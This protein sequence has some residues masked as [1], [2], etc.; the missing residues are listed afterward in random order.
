MAC[1]FLWCWMEVARGRPQNVDNAYTDQ[2]AVGI[3][4]TKLTVSIIPL[5]R[6]FWRNSLKIR[7][8]V[9]SISLVGCNQFTFTNSQEKSLKADICH[10][11]RRSPIPQPKP[12]AA[13]IHP[14]ACAK[15]MSWKFQRQLF[16]TYEGHSR[17]K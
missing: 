14:D 13:C 2:V 7:C 4:A 10:H 1:Y 12:P 3:I 15:V 17:K 16:G 6:G 11:I 5:F 8:L 9:L